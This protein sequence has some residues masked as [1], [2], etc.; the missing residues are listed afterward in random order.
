M[1]KGLDAQLCLTL[2]DSMDPPGSSTMGFSR[3]EYRS[4]LPCLSPGD[5]LNL[6]IERGP[7]MLQADSLL[8]EPPGEPNVKLYKLLEN[9]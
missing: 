7:P 9:N 6:G 4:G 3:Q 8:S 1:V 5:L 2:S